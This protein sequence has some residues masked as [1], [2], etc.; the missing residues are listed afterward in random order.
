MSIFITEYSRADGVKMT[1]PL[2]TNR[3]LIIGQ[4]GPAWYW[5]KA[6]QEWVISNG[7]VHADSLSLSH[8]EAI[9]ELEHVSTPKQQ[10]RALSS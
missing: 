10:Q 7:P 4:Y 8:M 1:R 5:D 2:A 3:W 9:H 6:N